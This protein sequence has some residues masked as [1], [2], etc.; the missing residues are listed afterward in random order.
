[1]KQDGALVG[2]LIANM[3]SMTW[4]RIGELALQNARVNV[5]YLD[6][7]KSLAKLRDV[8]MGNGDS[9]IIVAAGPSIR[10][11]NPGRLIAEYGYQGTVIATD[12][13]IAHCLRNGVVPHLVVSL[14]PHPSRIVRWF[15]DPTLSEK[16]IQADDYYRRQDL[17]PLFA[18]EMKANSEI[19]RLMTE[20]AHDIPIALAASASLAVLERVMQA[21]MP[22]Y[23][24]NPML[25]DPDDPAGATR[26]LIDLNGLPCVNA[27]GNV[28]SAAWMIADAVLGKKHVALVGM[29]FSYYDGTPYNA[30]QYYREAIDLVG[31]ENLDSVF[32]RIYNPHLDAWFISDPAYQW[33]KQCFLAMAA[34]ADCETYNCT[35]GGILF[36]EGINFCPLREFLQLF[37]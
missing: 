20:H 7:G 31:E 17:D 9:A 6:Q 24:W 25:D 23:W 16:T 5:G 29:D 34:D 26:R 18:D 1:M 37:A 32:S 28:G 3:E 10:R 13:G 11:H 12:S 8:E 19:I 30:T 27:G 14:D 4:Q 22:V 21:K 35:E 15:G 2:E 36:G 33:Y